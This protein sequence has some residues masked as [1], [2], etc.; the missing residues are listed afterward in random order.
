MRRSISQVAEVLKRFLHSFNHSLSPSEGG[1]VRKVP[2]KPARIGRSWHS[3]YVV[4]FGE[5]TQTSEIAG[6]WADLAEKFHQK[7]VICMDSYYFDARGRENLRLRQ[8]RYIAAPK[9]IASEA[10]SIF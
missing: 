7:N 10:S 5:S 3:Q 4:Q 1:I 8:V 6:E 2:S 9:L